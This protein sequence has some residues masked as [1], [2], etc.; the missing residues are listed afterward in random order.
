MRSALWPEASVEEHR[1]E[2]MAILDGKSPGKMPFVI[3][4]AE[5]G[6][7]L[8]GFLEVGL[9]SHADGCDPAV[10]VGYVEGWYVC[11]EHRRKGVGSRLMAAAQDWARAQGC[12]EMAS[13]TWIDNTSSQ[14]AHEALGFEVVDRCVNY[15][16]RL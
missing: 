16:K 10:P 8:A 13:D 7:S 12:V 15:K 11:G 1:K 6:G 4:V 3:F 9:R 2:L 5:D 14:Q